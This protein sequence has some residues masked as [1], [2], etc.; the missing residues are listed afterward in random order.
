[1]NKIKKLT[2]LLLQLPNSH[3]LVDWNVTIVAQGGHVDLDNLASIVHPTAD[4]PT[5]VEQTIIFI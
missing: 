4:E 5:T 1:M 3:C 2:L